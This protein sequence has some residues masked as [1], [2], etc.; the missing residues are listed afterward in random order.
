MSR[1]PSRRTSDNHS[2]DVSDA[3]RRVEQ[4]IEKLS[5][6]VLDEVKEGFSSETAHA[7]ET[8]AEQIDRAARNFQRRTYRGRHQRRQK[9]GKRRETGWESFERP[10]LT[11]SIDKRMVAGVCA[12]LAEY[13][14]METWV[15]RVG[16]LV[17]AIF[18]PHIVMAVYLIAWI[19]LPRSDRPKKRQRSRR[20]DISNH[21]PVAPEF[22][23]R[24]A[25]RRSLRTLR[26]SFQEIDR[27][28]RNLE[29]V[30]T[31]PNFSVRREFGKLDDSQNLRGQANQP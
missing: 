18:V 26:N 19:L 14:G 23:G 7:F 9:R 22:G 20:P 6:I 8:T 12:G 25:W 15:A 5:K 17:A 16:T 27:R 3:I 11:R 31:D 1:R 4:S 21:E 10:R 30:V 13:W 28:I 24:H 2:S 29:T